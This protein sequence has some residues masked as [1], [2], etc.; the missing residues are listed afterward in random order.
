MLRKCTISTDSLTNSVSI[1]CSHDNE[2][3]GGFR[4]E[5]V[6][7]ACFPE[8]NCLMPSFLFTSCCNVMSSLTSILC[9][10]NRT[11]RSETSTKTVYFLLKGT[12]FRENGQKLR[13]LILANYNTFKVF[14]LA[15]YVNYTE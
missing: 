11:T 4:T 15:K 8:Y 13:N 5:L 10:E 7:F 12:K 6:E 2:R 3:Y 14:A 1:L 9:L